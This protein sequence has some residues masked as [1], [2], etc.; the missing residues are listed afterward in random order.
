MPFWFRRHF[1]SIW[2]RTVATEDLLT[3]LEALDKSVNRP[4]F[5]TSKKDIDNGRI[6]IARE[7]IRRRV[8]FWT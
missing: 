3:A 1:F 4:I 5:E 2:A 6:R 7:L 8:I